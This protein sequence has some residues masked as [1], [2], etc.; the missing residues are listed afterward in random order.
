MLMADGVAGGTWK[1]ADCHFDGAG[2]RPAAGS[3]VSVGGPLPSNITADLAAE[4]AIRD[5]AARM[6][7][8][9]WQSFTD[10]RLFSYLKE[11]GA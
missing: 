4:L 1:R 6:L 9:C 11:I 7:Q 5:S 2:A 10:R 3:I 8:R